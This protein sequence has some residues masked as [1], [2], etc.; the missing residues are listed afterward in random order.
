[1]RINI[2]DEVLVHEEYSIRFANK[3]GVVVDIDW[4]DLLPYKVK[5]YG[6]Q[7]VYG[8]SADELRTIDEL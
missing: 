7:Q 4:N 1:M 5:I 3:W 6:G 2:G 8:F